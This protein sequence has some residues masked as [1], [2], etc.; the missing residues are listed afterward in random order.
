MQK[1]SAWI[2]KKKKPQKHQIRLNSTMRIKSIL[3]NYF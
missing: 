1:M 3:L 2:K